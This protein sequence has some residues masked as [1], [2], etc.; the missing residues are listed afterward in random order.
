SI[1]AGLRAVLV[2]AV[3]VAPA[4]SPPFPAAQDAAPLMKAVIKPGLLRQ[5]A[6]KGDVFVTLSIP[7]MNIAAG[8]PLVSLPVMLPG[9]SKPQAVAD[10]AVVD[11]SGPA[12]GSSRMEGGPLRWR[13]SRAVKGDVTITY[14]LAV[15]NT[16][17][18]A[19]GP[20]LDLRIDGDGFSGVAD[21]VIMAP[22]NQ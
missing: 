7:G 16:V 4:L 11:A 8:E 19:G 12:P 15:E 2:L 17:P 21:R 10:I 6:G 20:P 5:G 1:G 13:P 18:L 22:A 14:G 9:A 3:V